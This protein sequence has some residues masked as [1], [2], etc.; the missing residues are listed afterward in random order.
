MP[1]SY[2]RELYAASHGWAFA[3]NEAFLADV[4]A[5]LKVDGHQEKHSTVV[6]YGPTQAGKTTLILHLLG[7]QPEHV[8]RIA[9]VLRAESVKGKSATA[10]ALRYRRSPDDLWH[11]GGGGQNGLEDEEV[12]EYFSTL[13]EQVERRAFDACDL[14][15]VYLPSTCFRQACARDIDIRLID[16]PGL[17]ADNENE[18]RHVHALARRYVPYADLVLLT[19]RGDDLGSISPDA[20]ELPELRDWWIT[21]H[22]F[23]IVCTRG[24]VS[25][26]STATWLRSRDSSLSVDDVREHLIEQINTHEYPFPSGMKQHLYAIEIGESWRTMKQK[27]REL[28]APL[29][30][31]FM[32]GLIESVRQSAN[33]WFRLKSSWRLPSTAHLKCKSGTAEWMRDL[34]QI[35]LQRVDARKRLQRAQ[36]GVEDCGARIEAHRGDVAAVNDF[37]E[38]GLASAISK[39]MFSE[40]LSLPILYARTVKDICQCAD[41]FIEMLA[42]QCDLFAD[43]L[44]DWP[45]AIVLPTLGAPPKSAAFDALLA[46]LEG[47]WSDDYWFD[48]SWDEDIGLLRDAYERIRKEYTQHVDKVVQRWL[49]EERKKL[50]RKLVREEH[51]LCQLHRLINRRRA[52]LHDIEA[53]W[54]KAK[55]DLCEFWQAMQKYIEHGMSFMSHM[56]SA[57][58]NECRSRHAFIAQERNPAKKLQQRLMLPILE[59]QYVNMKKGVAS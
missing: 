39:K 53:K 5:S 31:E 7:V 26:G 20:L 55:V 59:K 19:C 11:V 23:C 54:L 14:I 37:V 36:K 25:D 29:V 48:G 1:S 6:L 22:R 32:Q 3:A 10:T 17:D 9:E 33:P 40:E 18:R 56:Q 41:D 8:E 27:D 38:T 34:C 16:L 52:V 15:D 43:H 12:K 49:D 13:R 57:Y 4:D 24:L 42:M 30:K 58:A 47:Y 2:W 51:R 35:R 50:F 46:K 45:E 28:C 44:D 21:P